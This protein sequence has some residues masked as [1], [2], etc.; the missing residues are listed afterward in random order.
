MSSSG[1][2]AKG[3]TANRD[4]NPARLLAVRRPWQLAKCGHQ[5]RTIANRGTLLTKLRS[6]CSSSSTSET[7]LR[8][9]L[10]PFIIAAAW[11]ALLSLPAQQQTRCGRNARAQAN[12]STE[13]TLALMQQ[14]RCGRNARAHPLF[15]GA[16][17]SEVS[18][19]CPSRL[20]TRQNSFRLAC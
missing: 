12:I 18:E 3:A 10:S 8:L 13:A 16:F 14:T 17:S 9:A 4:P 6:I 11:A 20:Q 15:A 1:K 7:L 19:L 2:S 5:A